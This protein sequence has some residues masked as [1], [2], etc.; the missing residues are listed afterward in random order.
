MC[1]FKFKWCTYRNSIW[2]SVPMKRRR[3]KKYKL[4]SISFVDELV[5]QVKLICQ[6]YAF[7]LND[8]QTT[9]DM[10]E[11]R[12]TTCVVFRTFRSIA[13]AS[14]IWVQP[15]VRARA[16][17]TFSAVTASDFRIRNEGERNHKTKCEWK[18]WSCVRGISQSSDRG[19]QNRQQ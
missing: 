15:R 17:F 4:K 9:T 10:Q 7:K 13:K 8:K 5:W 1:G 16:S 18:R 11:L 3:K 12:P 14:T 6:F 19:S 2:I